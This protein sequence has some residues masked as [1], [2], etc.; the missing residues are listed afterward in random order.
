M[1]KNLLI[2]CLTVFLFCSCE[3]M[4][5]DFLNE[6]D[7][8]TFVKQIREG[9]YNVKDNYGDI[10]LPNFYSDHIPELLEHVDDMSS[11]PSY[12]VSPISLSV[13]NRKLGICLLWTIEG[14]RQGVKY[15]SLSP[16]LMV[17]TTPDKQ[18]VREVT[19]EEAIAV[20]T[21]YKKWW[22]G[23]YPYNIRHDKFTIDPLEGTDY[24]WF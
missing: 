2:L 1:G 14:I 23:E 12:P 11:I 20:A 17:Y 18:D 3:R 13:G 15:P 5:S 8:K 16:T 19:N 9:S 4:E 21:L 7:V 24:A 22:K 6:P 10:T